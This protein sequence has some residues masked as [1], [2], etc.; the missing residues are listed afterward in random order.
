MATQIYT[1]PRTGKGTASEPYRPDVPYGTP[2][3]GSEKDGKYIIKTNG[4]LPAKAGRVAVSKGQD[5]SEAA[6]L[7]I[8]GKDL[9]DNWKIGG[10]K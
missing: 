10:Q 5:V 7:G 4:T 3:V 6:K 8:V 9:Q 1:T 2:W